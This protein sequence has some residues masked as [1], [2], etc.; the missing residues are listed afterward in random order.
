[1]YA[2]TLEPQLP[3]DYEVANH[4]TSTHPDSRFTQ[5]LVAQRL[6]TQ[7]RIRLRN[8]ELTHDTGK[9]SSSRILSGDAEI[10]QVLDATFGLAFVPGTRFPY[11]E[12]SG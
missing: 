7:A 10:L 3:I 11:L 6:T 4:Y 8:R 2:F 5:F 9:S 12:P 1:M